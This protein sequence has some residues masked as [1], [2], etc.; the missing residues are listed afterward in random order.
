MY[1][2]IILINRRKG[3]SMED[4]IDYY[5][6]GHAPLATPMLL[7]VRRYARNFLHPFDNATYR[8][9]TTGSPDVVTELWYDTEADF[10]AAIENLTK[11][12]NAAI[13]QADEEKLFDRSSI[14]FMVVEDKATKL[15]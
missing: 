12:E 1:K 6:N 9:D 2:V 11:P 7:N 4:F 3:M 15:P 5:E 13:L 14:R 10:R 8:A